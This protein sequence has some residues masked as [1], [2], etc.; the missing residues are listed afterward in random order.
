MRG[1]VIVLVL[2]WIDSCTYEHFEKLP[3]DKCAGSNLSI[4][5]VAKNASNCIAS[6]GSITAAVNGGTQPYSYSLK[7]GVF[8]QSNLFT[9]LQGGDYSVVVKDSLGCTATQF[10]AVNNDQTNIKISTSTTNDTGCP[11]ANGAIAISVTGAKKPIRYQLNSGQYQSGNSF[12]NL[13]AGSY[14]VAVN[15][16]TNCQASA[17]VT[18]ARNGPSFSGA[19]SSI[20]STNCG[21]NGCHNGSRNPNLSSYAEISSN[22]ASIVGAISSNM[23]PGKSLTQDQIN[24]ITCW[25]NDGVPNN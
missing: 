14:S 6:D 3:T 1:I 7:E 11:T 24:L 15:D 18:I 4:T 19:I 8:Q 21:I 9:N 2:V 5:V 17:T 22:G 12:A 13:K 10:A 25:V 20:I 23:P 16:S